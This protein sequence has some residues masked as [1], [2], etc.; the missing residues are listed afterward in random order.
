MGMLNGGGISVG[1]PFMLYS[2][3]A[4]ADPDIQALHTAI[5]YGGSPESDEYCAQP[6]ASDTPSN[7]LC[8]KPRNSKNDGERARA[9]FNNEKA[10]VA[11]ISGHGHN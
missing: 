4:N 10:S 7:S 8:P 1:Y 5:W 11:L 2:A 3:A 6:Q 9:E